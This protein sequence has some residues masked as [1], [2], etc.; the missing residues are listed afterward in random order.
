MSQGPSSDNPPLGFD[1]AMSYLQMLEVSVP[2]CPPLP[3]PLPS[4]LAP[5]SRLFW[6]EGKPANA[7]HVC[8][9]AVCA[10]TTKVCG[11]PQHLG[12]LQAAQVGGKG[13]AVILSPLP[14]LARVTVTVPSSR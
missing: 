3:S 7:T 12:G 11:V 13:P 2:L 1:N 4:H 10:A 5:I 9:Q 14:T 8:L 6:S